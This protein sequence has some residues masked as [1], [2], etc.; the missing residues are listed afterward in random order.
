MNGLERY[1]NLRAIL[2]SAALAG[3]EEAEANVL[4][5][6]EADIRA[7]RQKAATLDSQVTKLLAPLQDLTVDYTATGE[8]GQERTVAI[9]ISNAIT[10]FEKKLEAAVSELDGLWA[11]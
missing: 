2:H 10:T 4:T 8:D 5:R 6:S 7:N 1:A 11:S 9:A 3:L